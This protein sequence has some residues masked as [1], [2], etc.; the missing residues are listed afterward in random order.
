[1]TILRSSESLMAWRT[2]GSLNGFTAV[3]QTTL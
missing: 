2:R 3:L 1:M